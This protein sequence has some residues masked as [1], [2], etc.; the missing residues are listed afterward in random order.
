[1]SRCLTE[2]ELIELTGKIY[3][4]CQIKVLIERKWKFEIDGN[5]KPKV[6]RSYA[7]ARQGD[8]TAKKE[9]AVRD[10]TAPA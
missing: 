9:W 1:M 6:L 5:G 3:A 7:D 4:K 8:R 2:T 10:D